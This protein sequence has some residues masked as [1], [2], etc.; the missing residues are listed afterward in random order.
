MQLQQSLV[1]QLEAEQALAARNAAVQELQKKLAALLTASAPADQLSS[2][3]TTLAARA[4]DLEADAK[5]LALKTSGAKLI[6]DQLL[7]V[8]TEKNR[9]TQSAT[10]AE[11]SLGRRTN[12]AQQSQA[13]LAA[14]KEEL[15]KATADKQWFAT[16][17]S[18]NLTSRR[19]AEADAR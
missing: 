1:A 14:A 16:A 18:T 6:A 4:A 19:P 10:E 17:Y 7:A 5:T 2:M 11:Q 12:A 9:L 15:D 8:Q 3:Q 13:A